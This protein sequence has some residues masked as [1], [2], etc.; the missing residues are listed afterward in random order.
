MQISL[1]ISYYPL[2]PDYRDIIAAFLERLEVSGLNYTVG[3][4]STLIT[5]EYILVMQVLG[6]IMQDFFEKY[7]SIFTLKISNACHN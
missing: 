2:D 5:G 7:P 1:E 3:M 6:Y 4:M